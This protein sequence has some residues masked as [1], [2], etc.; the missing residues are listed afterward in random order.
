MVSVQHIGFAQKKKPK[1]N[2]IPIPDAGASTFY[3]AMSNVDLRIDEG[4][5]SA[6]AAFASKSAFGKSD[7]RC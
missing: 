1:V 7:Q 5:P 3:G 6:V 4:N 2:P